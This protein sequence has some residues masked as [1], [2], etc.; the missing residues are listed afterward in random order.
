MNAF[1]NG[2]TT[3]NIENDIL[4]ERMI[5][6]CAEIISIQKA[7]KIYFLHDISWISNFL[8]YPI[9]LNQ[10]KVKLVNKNNWNH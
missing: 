7:S 4:T 9:C 6:I 10:N 8:F 3:G 2:V 5:D 1:T